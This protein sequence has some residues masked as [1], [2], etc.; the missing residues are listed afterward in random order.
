MY[1]IKLM[2]LKIVSD[3]LNLDDYYPAKN[4]IALQSTEKFPANKLFELMLRQNRDIILP[5]THT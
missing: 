3:N 2:S 4:V 1:K 5:Q